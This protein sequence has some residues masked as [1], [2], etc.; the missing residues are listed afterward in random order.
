MQCVAVTA[1]G[2]PCR[3]HGEE[4]RGGLCHTHDPK[5]KYQEQHPAVAK[6]IAKRQR[7]AA[8]ATALA[9]IELQFTKM[10]P[11]PKPKMQCQECWGSRKIKFND[12][13]CVTF[14]CSCT[15]CWWVNGKEA[16]LSRIRSAR[17]Q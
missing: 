1:T 3:I 2:K 6:G 10:G 13:P 14:S 16:R 17:L 15:F 12:C 11:K 9:Q 7:E 5:G 8:L 4:A